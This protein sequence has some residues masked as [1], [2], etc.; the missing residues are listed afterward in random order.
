MVNPTMGSICI[1]QQDEGITLDTK[2]YKVSEA[3]VTSNTNRMKRMAA[4]AK[5]KPWKTID[6]PDER[7]VIQS[8]GENDK[9]D[10]YTTSVQTAPL[11]GLDDT[12]VPLNE[13]DIS[14]SFNKPNAVHSKTQQ[15][16]INI[17]AV[18][19]SAAAVSATSSKFT[20]QTSNSPLSSATGSPKHQSSVL[21]KDI[22]EIQSTKSARPLCKNIALA[23]NLNVPPHRRQTLSLK[24][25][26][27]PWKDDELFLTECDPKRIDIS[28]S[29]RHS[30]TRHFAQPPPIRRRRT[31]RNLETAKYRVLAAE[32]AHRMVIERGGANTTSHTNVVGDKTPES[33][34]DHIVG[35]KFHELISYNTVHAFSPMQ[36]AVRKRGSTRRNSGRKSEF[37]VA[38]AM[39]ETAAI[40]IAPVETQVA[41]SL[42]P[43][44]SFL[45]QTDDSGSTENGPKSPRKF[46]HR[47][48]LFPVPM[49][50]NYL[51]ASKGGR[52]NT[53]RSAEQSP[54]IQ[55]ISP[56]WLREGSFQSLIGVNKE[57]HIESSTTSPKKDITSKNSELTKSA[58]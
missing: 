51:C 23:S 36:A 27:T 15:S 34:P 18:N 22:N 13:S 21:G 58:V 38:Q 25:I 55:R 45:Q 16:T 53:A 57:D 19:Q 39:T 7:H 43:G 5:T 4:F 42:Q 56:K 49:K 32:L 41:L 50:P 9:C 24:L 20:C 33:H 3:S 11:F 48:S 47:P 52:G 8:S 12:R 6:F 2:E 46:K 35:H 28:K 44:L 1:Y 31:L 10:L 26:R 37:R 54:E 17:T 30:L 40:T 14:Q 29:P